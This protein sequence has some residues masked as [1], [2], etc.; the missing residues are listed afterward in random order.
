MKDDELR[1]LLKEWESNQEA[2]TTESGAEKEGKEEEKS[3]IEKILDTRPS[4]VGVKTVGSTGKTAA[5]RIA[6]IR[7]GK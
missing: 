1:N 7:K 6:A 5:E 4:A 3:D 2:D